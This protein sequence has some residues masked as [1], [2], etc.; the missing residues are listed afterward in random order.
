M[1][2]NLYLHFRLTMKD[3]LYYLGLAKN[4]SPKLIGLSKLGAKYKQFSECLPWVPLK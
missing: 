2:V 1:Y 3:K 4:L